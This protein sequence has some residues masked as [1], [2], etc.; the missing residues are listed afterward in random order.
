MR[1]MPKH[2]RSMSRRLTIQ[3]FISESAQR[4]GIKHALTRREH[5]VALQTARAIGDVVGQEGIAGLID[6]GK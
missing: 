4:L 2:R 1:N 3:N 6:L 5:G